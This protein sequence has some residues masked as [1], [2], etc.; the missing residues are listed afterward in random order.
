MFSIQDCGLMLE[1]QLGMT[2]KQLV[3]TAKQAEDLGFGYLLRSDHLLPTDNRRGLDSP[4]C[5]TSLGAIASSTTRLKF[6]PLVTPV[7]FRNPALLARM[8]CTLHSYSGGRLQLGLGAGW[9]EQEY[10]A[11]GFGFPSFSVRKA[12]FEEALSVILPL[13]REGRVDFDGKH[14]SAHTDCFPRPTGQFSVVIGG[15]TRSIMRVAARLA[16]EWNTL[17]TT[18]ESLAESASLVERFAAGRKVA[19]SEMA[20]FMLGRSQSE[21][22]SN[23]RMQLSKL[24]QAGTPEELLK[25]FR[26][27]SAPCGTPEE[28]V[29][30]IRRKL[31]AGVQKFY[32][33]TLVPEN[34]AMTEL[35]A[36]TLKGSFA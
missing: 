17:V 28:F 23:A 14:Y 16:D 18:P 36:D 13:I 31:E 6:G 12:Q 26:A 5:W 19:L 22:E 29:D 24:G 1:P 9:Y 34:A 10:A 7:G 25:R 2:M 30:H 11:H 27:R 33:Q 35:L 21:L 3:A 20:P 15:K 8:A 4:E 32:F